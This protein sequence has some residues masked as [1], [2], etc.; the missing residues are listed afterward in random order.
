MCVGYSLCAHMVP[1]RARLI[2]VSDYEPL[3]EEAGMPDKFFDG[4]ITEVCR[5]ILSCPDRD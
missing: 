2:P 3:V 4:T 5:H 1:S